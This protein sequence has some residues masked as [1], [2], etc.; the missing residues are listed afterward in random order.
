MCFCIEN[1]VLNVVLKL[2]DIK[3][4]M[5]IK[6]SSVKSLNMHLKAYNYPTNNT[7]FIP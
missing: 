4:Q 7:N 5:S 6:S 1:T 3:N 2:V